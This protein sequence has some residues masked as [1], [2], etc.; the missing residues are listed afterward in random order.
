MTTHNL[1]A[2][3]PGWDFNHGGDRASRDPLAW[4]SRLGIGLLSFFAQRMDG[5]AG[6]AAGSQAQSAEAYKSRAAEGSNGCGRPYCCCL[7]NY[8]GN[9]CPA[10]PDQPYDYTCPPNHQKMWWYCT[11]G[12]T[13]YGCGECVPMTSTNCWT[14]PWPCSKWWKVGS[15]A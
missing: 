6:A 4:L 3:A 1:E 2:Y 8:P 7:A 13:T 5:E 11:Q 10:P 15:C 9:Q 14:G 12:T